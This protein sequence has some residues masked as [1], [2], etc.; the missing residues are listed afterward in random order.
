MVMG[1]SS[2]CGGGISGWIL[3]SLFEVGC[4]DFLI[5]RVRERKLRVRV[6]GKALVLRLKAWKLH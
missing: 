4:P 5:L 1:Q 3:D 6:D 2:G